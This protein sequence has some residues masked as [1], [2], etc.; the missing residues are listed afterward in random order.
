MPTRWWIPLDDVTDPAAI[1][2]D[3]THAALASWLDPLTAD[4]KGVPFDE[5][6]AQRLKPWFNAP[7]SRNGDGQLGLEVSTLTDHLTRCLHKGPPQATLRL[8]RQH[9]RTVAPSPIKHASWTDIDQ[10]DFTSTWTLAFLTPTCFRR[11]GSSRVSALPSPEPILRQLNTYWTAYSGLKSRLGDHQ[12]PDLVVTSCHIRT[13]HVQLAPAR[14]VPHNQRFPSKVPGFTGHLTLEASPR[15]A[16]SIAPLMQLI[17]YVNIGS[18]ARRGL[19]V[20]R[21]VQINEM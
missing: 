20:T 15:D 21:L 10:S 4:H 2:L 5:E 18:F 3:H 1:R 12:T 7:L 19:G 17:D 6:H 14:T 16:S 9:A 11:R 8:G 13:H